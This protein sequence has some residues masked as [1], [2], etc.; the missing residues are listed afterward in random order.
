M[1]FSFSFA[2][3]S[4]PPFSG[5]WGPFH[6]P[7]IYSFWPVVWWLLALGGLQ[8]MVQLVV[9]ELPTAAGAGTHFPGAALR[10]Q[11]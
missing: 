2:F 6:P 7:P 3:L 10:K 1:G 11:Y 5:L 8:Q 4:S 9:S